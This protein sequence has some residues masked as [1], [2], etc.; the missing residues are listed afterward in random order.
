MVLGRLRSIGVLV[1]LLAVAVAVLGP[2]A[3]QSD[4]A[5]AA[6]RAYKVHAWT[7]PSGNNHRVRWNPCQTITYSVNVRK[8]GK[9]S[10]VRN[11]AIKDVRE[12]F[13]RAS[14]RTG[15][16]FSF[17]GRTRELPREP[18]SKKSWADRQRSSEI[19]VA[20]VDQSRRKYRSNLLGKSG[21]SYPSGVGGWMLKGW[22][23]S[24]G[25]WQAAVGRGFVVINAGDNHAYRKGFGSGLTRGALL[26]HEIGHSLGLDHV[27][28]TN[29]LMYP[30]LLRR[31]HSNYKAGDTVGLHKVGKRQ[32]CIPQANDQWSQI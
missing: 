9:T 13:R 3:G 2:V 11:S 5:G 26:L 19:V 15:L 16:R 29:E 14:K 12:A 18:A 30:T 31:Q 28:S 22:T 20:W 7:D 1:V 21:S 17:E 25:R 32:G 10:G 27:G 8:A 23:D 6:G 4:R 24:K